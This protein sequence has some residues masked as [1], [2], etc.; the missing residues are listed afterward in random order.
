MNLENILLCE[1][2]QAQKVTYYC[3]PFIENV[4]VGQINKDRKWSSSCWKLNG[5]LVEITNGAT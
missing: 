4:Q 1:R 3:I 5:K 2:S